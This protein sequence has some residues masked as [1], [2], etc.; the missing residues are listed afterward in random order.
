MVGGQVAI[1]SAPIP[2]GKGFVAAFSDLTC[3]R[4]A[5][6]VD[7]RRRSPDR[8]PRA[9]RRPP[10]GRRALEAA[11][12]VD[13]DAARSGS[14]SIEAGS[15]VARSRWR[16][17]ALRPHSRSEGRLEH[18]CRRAEIVRARLR[19][20]APRAPAEADGDRD[21]AVP[22]RGSPHLPQGRVA[23][24]P[25][26]QSGPRSTGGRRTRAVLRLGS[27]RGTDARRG[28]ERP[29]GL[30]APGAAR[31]PPDG[32]ELPAPVR[33]QSASA[34]RLRA[35]TIASSP[36]MRPRSTCSATHARSSW[37]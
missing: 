6:R 12:E 32:G 15:R 21:A 26:E 16:E 31:T 10:Y 28:R 25:A 35:A 4:T 22:A 18:L 19:H 9:D 11:I 30:G 8:L 37:A 5:P 13:R 33:D 1:A 24:P 23:D 7:L 17:Q 34:V 14:R 2:G 3:T 36:S 27:R 29:D 20:S